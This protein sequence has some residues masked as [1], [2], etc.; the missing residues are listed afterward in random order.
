MS[1]T[2]IVTITT[3]LLLGAAWSVQAAGPPFELAVKQDELFGGR[4]GT[5]VFTNEAIEYRTGDTDEGRQ[6]SYV[7][8]KQVRVVSPTDIALAT[9]QDQGLLR[10]GA[11]RT[12]HFDVIEGA[13]GSDLVE[14][15]LTRVDRPIVTAVLPP[16]PVEPRFRLPVKY[17][18]FGKGS[19]GALLLYDQGLAYVTE[20]ERDARYWRLR[21]LYA[22]LSLDRYRLEIRAY[23][24]G[25]GETRPF[26]FQLKTELP[27][28]MH[29][30]LW[31]AANPASLTGPNAPA[32]AAASGWS[33]DKPGAS[34][35]S[36]PSSD[37]EESK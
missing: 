37:E 26:T 33:G 7:D 34:E 28:E 3:A 14:F 36:G 10:L 23:E 6:W 24:G 30:A 8:L 18:R 17:Q 15:L 29:E 11:D 5:L 32:L 22:V 2:Q 16:L 21:D 4:R 13:I 25:G 1:N 12:Y 20:R 9:Y 35:Q 31:Q 27:A 19:E